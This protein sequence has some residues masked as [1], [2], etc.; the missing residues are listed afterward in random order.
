MPG[1][2]GVEKVTSR[3][4]STVLVVLVAVTTFLPYLTAQKGSPPLSKDN[5]VELL[6]GDVP[7]VRVAAI[8][9]ERRVSF[10]LTREVED[11]IRKDGGDDELI[12]AIRESGPAQ[13]AVTEA[14]VAPAVLTVEATPGSAQVYVDDELVGTTSSSGLLKLSHLTPGS[15]RVR[16]GHVGYRDHEGSVELTAGHTASLNVDLQPATPAPVVNPPAPLSSE[17]GYLGLQL[18]QQQ[19]ANENGVMI[20][21][22][23]PNGPA[24]KAGLKASD[25]VLRIAG[26]PVRTPQEVM[27]AVSSHRAGETIEISWVSDG[28]VMTKSVELIS[29]PAAA[30]QQQRLTRTSEFQSERGGSSAVVTQ[31]VRHDHGGGRDCT[32]I[33]SVGNGMVRYRSNDG[34]HSFD[35]LASEIREA[36]R[37]GMYLSVINAFHIRLKNGSNYN[38]VALDANGKYQ[39]PSAILAAINRAMGQR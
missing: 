21:G 26:V 35:F 32:G 9:R 39:F 38:F 24:A 20:M 11:E 23:D 7:P 30:V 8:V 3:R 1:F 36:K 12:K 17:P 13:P 37:N 27:T 18:D 16:V 4:F 19:P 33:L 25:T 14:T 15:H 2:Y 10:A 22:T 5:I 31:A 29:R 28:Q 34:S 6:T